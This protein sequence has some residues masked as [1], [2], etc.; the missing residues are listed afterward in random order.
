M[1]ARGKPLTEFENFKAQLIGRMKKLQLSFIDDFEHNFDGM[2]TDLFW[3]KNKKDFDQIYYAFFGVLLM[4]QSIII[5]DKSWANVIE[6]GNIDPDI[7]KAAFYTL[8]FLCQKPDDEDIKSLIFNAL[9]ERRTYSNRVMFHAVTTYLLKSSGEDKGTMKQW[10]RIVTNLVL[11]STIDKMDLYHNAIE[12]INSLAEYWNSLNSYFADKNKVF[13]FN[14]QQIEEEQIKAKIMMNNES[15]AS[16]I[17]E[18]ERHPYFCGQVRSALYLG[19]NDKEYDEGQFIYYWERISKLFD[20]TKPKHGL[21][22]R[23]ALLTFGDYTLSVS[24]FKTLCVDDPNEATNTPGLKTLFANCGTIVKQ[25]L[26]VLDPTKDIK[27]QLEEI[28]NKSTILGNDWRYCFIHYPQL[29]KWMSVSHLR[30][31][32][33]NGEMHIIQNKQANGYNYDLYLSALFEELKGRDIVSLFDAELGVWV[34]H[35]LYVK[36]Y[37]ITFS[38][39]QYYVKDKT[40]TTIFNS[41]S[42]DPIIETADYIVSIV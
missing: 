9:S 37:S 34:E 22:L 11:N 29:F 18:A 27:L 1:N 15:F 2:W 31:R 39:R 19:K 4:N 35:C 6:Y 5:D 16:K 42:N 3:Q 7:F 10:L 36:E 32:V 26:C 24:Q 40:K 23:R 21:L 20:V 41:K 28:I 17:L 12:S 38:E 30:L 13:G 8:N 33:L 25:L 14:Q